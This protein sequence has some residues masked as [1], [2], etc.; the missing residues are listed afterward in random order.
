[1]NNKAIKVIG[2]IFGM[3][4]F[5]YH[6]RPLRLLQRETGEHSG[7]ERDA[8]VDE[9]ALGDFG[10]GDVHLYRPEAQ[11]AGNGGQEEV[12]VDGEEQHL[13]DRVER[14]QAG[15]VLTVAAREVVPDDDHGDAA[16]QTDQNEAGHVFGFV[17]Q[18]KHGEREHQDRPDHPVLDQR[19]DQDAAVLEHSP[20]LFVLHLRQRRIH[21]Q[22]QPDGD[23]D[24]CRADAETVE[25]RY[26]AGNQVPEAN[27]SGHGSENPECKIPIEKR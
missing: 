2:L 20:H 27:S 3:N 26:D 11:P 10:H 21:H 4:F 17:A 19:E 1:M 6:S 18:K 16:G 8:Q 23:R 22:D 13:E 14:D 24:G 5:S 15:G 7:E 25:E 12:R 9:D